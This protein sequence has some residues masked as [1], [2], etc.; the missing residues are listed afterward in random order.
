MIN[1]LRASR[2]VAI[3]EV[4]QWLRCVECAVRERGVWRRI[5]SAAD[6]ARRIEHLVP[7]LAL[8][9]ARMAPSRDLLLG[10]TLRFPAPSGGI[11]T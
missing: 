10:R 11:G 7:P 2:R 5:R 9:R 8:V 6:W 3:R 4:Q 1:A